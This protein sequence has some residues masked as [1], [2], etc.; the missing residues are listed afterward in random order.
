MRHLR[1]KSALVLVPV[2]IAGLTS[3]CGGT[4]VATCAEVFERAALTVDSVES[5]DFECRDPFGHS[6]YHGS[7]AL[8]VDTQSEANP[9]I[10]EIYRAFAAESELD[11]AWIPNI[12][13]SQSEGNVKFSGLDVELEFNGKPSVRDMREGYGISPTAGD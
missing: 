8:T 5:A 7:I 11:N 13:F 12:A 3:G 9:V 4:D 10:D 1:A 6:S 2:A